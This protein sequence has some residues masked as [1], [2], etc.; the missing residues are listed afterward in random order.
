MT[1]RS[2]IVDRRPAPTGFG[3]K[4]HQAVPLWRDIRVIQAVAQAVFAVVVIAVI[5]VVV[6][7][8]LNAVTAI[9]QAPNLEFWQRPIG[10]NFNEGPGISSTDTTWRAFL[11]GLIN[12]LRAVS[13]GLVAS[14][15]LGVLV[16]IAL[17]TP[18]WLVRNIT[19]VYVEIFRNT[20]LLVQLIFFY[21]GVF[22]TLPQ[23][24][25]AIVLP[26][27]VYMSIRGLVIPAFHPTEAFP[28]WLLYVLVGFVVAAFLWYV[29]GRYQ[30]ETGQPGYQIRVAL[31]AVLGFAVLGILVLGGAPWHIELPQPT[32]RDLPTGET[33]IQRIEG[34]ETVSPEYSAMVLGLVLYTA[35]FIGE[36]VRAGI[37]AVPYGQIEAARAQGFTYA[38]TLQLIILP[39]ALRV[40]IPP[41]GNQ[42]L[43]LA[44]NS[45]LAIAIAFADVFAIARTIMNQSGQTIV[46]FMTVMGVYLLMSLIISAVMNALNRAL[47]LKER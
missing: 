30:A 9:G 20:P 5:F 16:G 19:Q 8:I 3:V 36:I 25:D 7:N 47:Q 23:I 29:R 18:N 31:L 43:N 27:P 45:S 34:G 33:I 17:L 11:V 10:I 21:Q 39:Q 12:T 37:Q 24:R 28:L 35:A 42:Y 22:R 6:R 26:G 44:K 2:P 38:Q 1:Q 13:I 15:I 14:T 32:Y 4:R 40:I 41:L 46:P